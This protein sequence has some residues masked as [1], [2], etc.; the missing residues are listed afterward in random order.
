MKELASIATASKPRHENASAAVV[1][2]IGPAL[3]KVWEFIRSQPSLGLCLPLKGIELLLTIPP[4]QKKIPQSGH[5]N[6]DSVEVIVFFRLRPRSIEPARQMLLQ[7]LHA[8]QAG[9]MAVVMSGE[10]IQGGYKCFRV[11]FRNQNLRPSR[12]TGEHCSCWL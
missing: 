10:H 8:L 9:A 5:I 3:G 7:A 6:H 1:N 12:K 2:A 4:P 11:N